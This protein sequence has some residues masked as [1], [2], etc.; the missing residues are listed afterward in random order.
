MYGLVD[1][2]ASADLQVRRV[3]LPKSHIVRYCTLK[4]A[5]QHKDLCKYA[6]AIGPRNQSLIVAMD[7]RGM[8]ED[9]GCLTK[10]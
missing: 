5:N 6:G 4:E 7:S 9:E 1:W 2:S 8:V 10:L 3:R